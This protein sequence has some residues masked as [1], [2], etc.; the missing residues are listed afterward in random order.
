MGRIDN[1]NQIHSH[2][3][4]KR[5]KLNNC[6]KQ[7]FSTFE[8]KKDFIEIKLLLEK[9]AMFAAIRYLNEKLLYQFIFSY[10]VNNTIRKLFNYE[11]S[12]LFHSF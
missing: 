1:R 8:K 6:Q 5:K 3:R 11:E 10:S 2:L 12:G 4:Y 9:N 7:H